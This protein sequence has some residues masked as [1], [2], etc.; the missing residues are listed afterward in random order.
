MSSS[1]SMC[2]CILFVS[3]QL[4]QLGGLYPTAVSLGSLSMP[5]PVPDLDKEMPYDISLC[6]YL[7]L[8]LMTRGKLKTV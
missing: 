3:A 2:I 6:P 8:I 5:C 4:D 1:L 7:S